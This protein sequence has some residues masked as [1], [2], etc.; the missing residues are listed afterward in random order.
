VDL[1]RE[2]LD[3]FSQILDLILEVSPRPQQTQLA[4]VEIRNVDLV[5]VAHPDQ[6]II[7]LLLLIEVPC[8]GLLQRRH[9]LDDIL[10]QL[11]LSC[12]M[13]LF[14]IQLFLLS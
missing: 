5:C 8:E 2:D 1:L 9:C 3:F 4:A 12:R 13:R 6:R 11:H 14:G 7:G 10:L